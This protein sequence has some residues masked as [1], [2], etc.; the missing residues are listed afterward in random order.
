MARKQE[1]IRTRAFVHV[2]DE[3]V[4]IDTLSAEQ[5]SYIGAMLRVTMLN[6]GYEG[7]AVFQAEGLPERDAVFGPEK[8]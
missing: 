3:L 5:R 8:T 7:K 2:G 4:D 6:A 1:P